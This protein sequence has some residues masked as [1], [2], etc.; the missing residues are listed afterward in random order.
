MHSLL[1]KGA[2]LVVVLDIL[3]LLAIVW[4]RHLWYHNLLTKSL[5]LSGDIFAVIR[6]SRCV[7]KLRHRNPRSSLRKW[8]MVQSSLTLIYSRL[9]LCCSYEST[10]LWQSA[11]SHYVNIGMSQLWAWFIYIVDNMFTR[12][13]CISIVLYY[14]YR[15]N[16]LLFVT[17][18]ATLL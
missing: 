18:S 11:Q 13:Y 5:W 15:N 7:L 10:Q 4:L 6:S 12:W 17:R 16:T 2:A 8:A 1:T 9:Q 14:G 3:S